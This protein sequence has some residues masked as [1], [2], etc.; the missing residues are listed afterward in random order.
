[1]GDERKTAFKIKEGLYERH[2]MP[3][4]LSNALSTFMWFMNQ[5]LKP[6]LNNFVVVYFGDILKKSI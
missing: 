3:F 5:V 4:G 6:L 2:V 1:M